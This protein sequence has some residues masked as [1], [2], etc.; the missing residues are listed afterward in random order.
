MTCAKEHAHSVTRAKEK[1]TRALAL[2]ANKKGGEE[3][4]VCST[5]DDPSPPSV[6]LLEASRYSKRCRSTRQ[7]FPGV[8]SIVDPVLC[9]RRRAVGSVAVDEA[10]AAPLGPSNDL[11]DRSG[12]ETARQY[13]RGCAGDAVD[14]SRAATE[15]FRHPVP[16]DPAYGTMD[17]P[18]KLLFC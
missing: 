10:I 18:P 5:S 4:G 6:D 9:R 3:G 2:V 16:I 15:P 17:R 13:E 14:A 12:A 7:R 1:Q 8:A 11:V